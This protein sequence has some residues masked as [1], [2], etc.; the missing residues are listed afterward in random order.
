MSRHVTSA[1]AH[2]SGVVEV[3]GTFSSDD[4]FAILERNLSQG[5]FENVSFESVGLSRESFD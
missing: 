1:D 5:H 2:A 4:M 3:T